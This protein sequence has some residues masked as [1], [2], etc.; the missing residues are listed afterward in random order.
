MD[1]CAAQEGEERMIDVI[2]MPVGA[3]ALLIL[4]GACIG[5]MITLAVNHWS[6][7]T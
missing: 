4:A 1:R 2:A 5:A 6:R 7:T 3:L